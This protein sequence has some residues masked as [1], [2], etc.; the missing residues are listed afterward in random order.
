MLSLQNQVKTQNSQK[1]K[2]ML[3]MRT[4]IHSNNLC[5]T[6]H[7]MI[8][9]IKMRHL[10]TSLLSFPQ[11]MKKSKFLNDLTGKKLNLLKNWNRFLT[12]NFNSCLLKTKL[13]LKNTCKAFTQI[14]NNVLLISK[15]KLKTLKSLRRKKKR[16]K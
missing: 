4:M 11:Q 14:S 2:T 13:I 15:L 6:R 8:V 16:N 9:K 1:T 12:L 7:L 3:W 10:K 5:L